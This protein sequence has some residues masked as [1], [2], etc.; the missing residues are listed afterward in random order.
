VVKRTSVATDLDAME[1]CSACGAALAV[2]LQWC[3]QCFA[4]A[5]PPPAATGRPQTWSGPVAPLQRPAPAMRSTRWAKTT[6]TF[7]PAGRLL[8]TFGLLVPLVVMIVGG[9]ADPF[10]WGGAAVWGLI[11]MPWGLR[12]VWKAGKVASA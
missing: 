11:V 2:G 7:G 6:T 9:L 3:G 4:P 1:R 12:D 5:A 10:A 8:A